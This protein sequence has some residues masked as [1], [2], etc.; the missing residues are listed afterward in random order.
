[1]MLLLTMF[2]NVDVSEGGMEK[3]GLLNIRRKRKINNMEISELAKAGLTGWPLAFAAV[4]ITVCVVSL[5]IGWPW[6]GII[7]IHKHYHNECEECDCDCHD[8][9]ED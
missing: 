5:F 4:S 7:N 1:M 2:V 8:E 3:S 9:D 6:E